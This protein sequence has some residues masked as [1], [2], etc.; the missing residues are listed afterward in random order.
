MRRTLYVE[1][2]RALCEKWLW[3]LSWLTDM[4][5]EM[6]PLVRMQQKFLWLWM[7]TSGGLLKTYY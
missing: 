4:D 1:N 6:M 3:I 5:E 2:L 7:G